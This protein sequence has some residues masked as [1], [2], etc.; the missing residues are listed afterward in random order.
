[1]SSSMTSYAPAMRSG[2]SMTIVTAGTCL[3]SCSSRSPC[4]AWSPWKKPSAAAR[5]F[6]RHQ[7]SRQGII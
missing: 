2:V 3:P 6:G 7:P 1:V 4:G 5:R